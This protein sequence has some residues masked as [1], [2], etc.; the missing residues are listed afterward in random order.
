MESEA[1]VSQTQ[2]EP[3]TEPLEAA[4][5]PAGEKGVRIQVAS[6][7]FETQAKVQWARLQEAEPD[8]L[9]RA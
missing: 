3:E 5:G 1:T 6:M 8:L 4:P 7:R 2:T 9:G